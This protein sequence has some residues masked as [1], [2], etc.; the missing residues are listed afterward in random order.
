MADRFYRRIVQH[1]CFFIARNGR[2]TW[3]T[4]Q[5][6]GRCPSVSLRVILLSFLMIS[7][8][9]AAQLKQTRRVLI[10]NDL[11]IVSSPG[12]AEIDQAILNSLQR[13]PYQI[14]L[15]DESLQLTFFPDKDSQRAFYDSLI[16]KYSGR[17]PDLIIAAGSASFK[18]VAESHEPFIRETPIIFCELLGEIPDQSNSGLHVTGVMSRLQPEQTLEAALHLLPG[19]KHVA[20]VGGTGKFDEVWERVAKQAFQNYES[21]L[22]FTYLTNLT[23]PV[24]LERLRHLPSNTIVYHTSIAQDAAG[25]RFIGSAQSVPLVADAANAPVFVMDDVDLRA[26]TVGGSLVDWT[27][28]G[29]IAGDMA[30]RV[31]NGERP[32][33]IPIEISKNAYMFD[34][35]A[36][37]RWHLRESDLPPGSVVLNRQPSFWEVYRGYVIAALIVLLAEAVA[38]FALLWQR[39]Q[40]RKAETELRKSEEKFSKAF[41]R[42]PLAFTLASLVDYRFIEVN[43]TFQRYT[44]WQRDEVV[45]RTP[46]EINLWVDTDQR[47][48]FLAQ[49]RAEGSVRRMELLFCAKDGHFWTGLVSS[50]LIELNGE[51][52]AL[53]LIA[54][55]T[56][57]KRAELARRE[58]ED[59]F[60]L[61][62]NAAPVMIWIS[63]P[64]K[65]CN[66][67]NQRWLEFTGRSFEQERGN[68]WVEGVHRD[69]VN[70]CLTTYTDSFDRRAPFEMQ[71]R[72][73]RDDGEYRWVLDLGVPR[74]NSDG[75]F[76]GYIGTCVDITERKLAQEAL[77]DIG[78]KLIEAQEEERAWIARELH[79]DINQRIAVMAVELEQWEQHLYD[80]EANRGREHIRRVRERLF[81]LGKDV[82]LLS[83]RLHSSKLEL[84]GLVVAASSFC[85]EFSKQHK[86]EV[87]FSHR[88]VPRNLP[89]ETS[90]CLYRV[91]QEAL[92]NALKHSG[93]RH[94]TVEMHGRS[95]EIQMDVSD[96][97]V[98]F[99]Q[100]DAVNCDGLGLISMR[101]R[102]QMVKG[103]L[104]IRSEPG[105]GTTIQ[106]LVPLS[107]VDGARAAG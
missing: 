77:S 80:S 63:G 105:R 21:K 54:D 86:V 87:D 5:V 96:L 88:D 9:S 34:W 45:G 91:L 70:T 78:R 61:V 29:R 82:Q 58:S 13:S 62:A 55:I 46:L 69:D 102:L 104:S 92:Q 48:T 97:G 51:P 12:F 44:G 37:K 38:I 57:A 4:R 11:G 7:V 32:E 24:L 83:H 27:D 49:L 65:L 89:K 31:L 98:G 71:Y 22:E 41:Q 76:A 106:A 23:M 95:G 6:F 14:E 16:R 103:K 28:A 2:Q 64:D 52:C 53:S 93:G 30:V 79:D 8:L 25:E 15:Y 81:D 36:L 35:R 20:I 19:T 42:S 59:R 75:S 72:L 99:V 33:D 73:R 101:E 56:E 60:R 40:R 100:H 68:G 43:D 85:R 1:F 18:L 90:L 84:L 39:V 47:S 50:E 74:F 3:S 66:Y 94:F 26:G 17:R 67:F 10:I 107:S